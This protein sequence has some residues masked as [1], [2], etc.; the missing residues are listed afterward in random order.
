MR[1]DAF[2]RNKAFLS[3]AI[4]MIIV[5]AGVAYQSV[6]GESGA[7]DL[8]ST[9][10]LASS[11]S[12]ADTVSS[13]TYA[14]F[15]PTTIA[16]IAE[17]VSKSVVT[18]EAV[19]KTT[20]RTPTRQWPFVDDPILDPF[21]FFFGIDPYGRQNP[22]DYTTSSG[23]GFIFTEDG[24]ILT[25]YHVVSGNRTIKVTL[26]DGTEYEAQIVRSMQNPDVAVLKIEPGDKQ[27]VPVK[28]GQSK[29]VRPGEWT[30]AIGNPLNLGITVTAGIVSATHR[31]DDPK[32]R[33][34][35]GMSSVQVPPTGFIQTDAAINPGNSGGPLLNLNGEVIGINTAMA[36]DGQNVG[37][38]IP[39][40]AISDLLPRLM[41]KS[42]G[43]YLG[44]GVYT[45][46]SE[47]ASRLGVSAGAIV[48]VVYEGSPAA[49]AGLQRWDAIVRIGDDEIRTAD[50]LVFTISSHQPGDEV[51]VVF[52]RD[53]TLKAVKVKLAE[54]PSQ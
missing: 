40:D 5:F 6:F 51:E 15:G 52:V 7:A 26:A 33:Q 47:Y 28:L 20:Q 14:P 2:R 3:L 23:T 17:R 16:D 1:F 44:V 50:D 34:M 4:A 13:V 38:A 46:D 22:E 45:I 24:Y 29:N 32:A 21:F 35:F 18:I 25:N 49:E 43:G 37:F 54:A 39:I 53:K 42:R 48:D 11:A 27:L 12:S 30:I 10:P 19:P 31:G 36:V 9:Q 41:T 8:S